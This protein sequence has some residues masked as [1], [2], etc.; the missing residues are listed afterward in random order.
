LAIFGSQA[1][2]AVESS[3]R[4]L[5]KRPDLPK[6]AGNPGGFFMLF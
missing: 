4:I 3:E 2:S 1:P 6:T 5:R